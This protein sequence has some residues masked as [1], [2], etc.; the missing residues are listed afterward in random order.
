MATE[1][2]S[3][4]ELD[5]VRN[6]L[7]G[8]YVL[9]NDLTSSDSDYDT[10]ASSTANGGDGWDP[11]GDWG[12]GE[13]FTGVF[14]GGDYEI[15][16]MYIDR[17]SMQGV[18]LFS[19]TNSTAEIKNIHV[20]DFDSI[21]LEFLAGIVGAMMGESV[22]SSSSASGNATDDEHYSAILVGRMN[23]YSQAKHC[24]AN[25]ITQSN[26][27]SGIIT[28]GMFNNY[29]TQS[30]EARIYQ[31]Y[32]E[33][34]VNSSAENGWG[35]GLI[36]TNDGKIKNCYSTADVN[37]DDGGGFVGQLRS[38]RIDKCYSTGTVTGS[39]TNGFI[40]YHYDQGGDTGAY[41][42]FYDTETSGQSTDPQATGKTTAEMQD[43]ATYTDTATTGLDNPW[44]FV[45]D[46][47]DD[48]GTENIWDINTG[49]P[50]LTAF[51]EDVSITGTR[52]SNRVDV[53]AVTDVYDSTVQWTSTEPAETEVKIYTAIT[54]GAE[55]GESD[56]QE[57][58]NGGSI[59]GV[60]A[61]DD[62]S[63]KYIWA[64]QELISE[65]GESTPQLPELQYYIRQQEAV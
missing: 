52:I 32:A 25:G 54:T 65:D 5:A 26:G 37:S 3:W 55:P 10:Y 23:D 20:I 19:S 64:K 60:T 17:P 48:T 21:G 61:G 58:N 53:G 44:D 63:G 8:D 28:A 62:M 18:A 38:G 14:D 34:E 42:C 1:I 7:A 47:N 40:G 49:Y 39:N 50:F 57:A 22:I 15:Q 12:A 4:A 30:G 36:G 45:G 29:E 51:V 9:V 59:P 6:D 41:N 56:W 43:V 33:G 35:G 13:D 24:Y 46:P 31:C 2:S 27:W 11:I 16:D